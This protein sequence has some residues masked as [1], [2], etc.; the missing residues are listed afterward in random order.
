MHTL[1]PSDLVHLDQHFVL[2]NGV[3]AEMDDH[4]WRHACMVPAQEAERDHRDVTDLLVKEQGV[5][6]CLR[7]CESPCYE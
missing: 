7:H 4:E 3:D 1:H 6:N 5:T 2:T